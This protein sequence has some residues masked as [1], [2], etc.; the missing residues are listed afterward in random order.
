MPGIVTHLQSLY[1]GS[2]DK[3]SG[4]LALPSPAHITENDSYIYM[5]TRLYIYTQHTHIYLHI[6][7]TRYFSIQSVSH[8]N[9][10]LIVDKYSEM[11]FPV[12][13]N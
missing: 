12:S 8:I 7:D 13:F 6:L 3:D 1:W 11:K 2:R 4:S 5:H 10:L 9:A